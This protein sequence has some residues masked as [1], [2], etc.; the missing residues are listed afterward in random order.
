VRE[1]LEEMVG[2][3][4][5]G[6][7]RPQ[8]L[9]ELE[10]AIQEEMK[11]WD[12]TLTI[13]V[14]SPD[15]AKVFELG[16]SLSVD[17]GVLT[18]A[19]RKGNGMQ[20]A[21][22]LALTQAWAGALRKVREADAESKSRTG[23]NT[24]I[25]AIEEPELYLHPHAERRHY[26]NLLDLA[27]AEEHQVFLSSHS[28]HFVDL[29][30]PKSICIL[31]KPDVETGTVARQCKIELFAGDDA[32]DRKKR[33][34]AARWVNPVRGEMLF[35]RRVAFVEG[36]TEAALFPFLADKLGCFDPEVSVIECA[37]K[38]N[39]LLYVEIAKVF[40]LDFIVVHDE[41]PVAENLEGDK[42]KTARKTYAYNEQ[43]ARL[44]ADNKRVEMC[45]PDLEGMAGILGGKK[46]G[47]PLTAIEHFGEDGVEI[48][49]RLE[50]V[51]RAVY[52]EE[53]GV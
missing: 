19:D 33:F 37:S 32:A 3:L 2:H 4:N 44:V 42:L 34:R 46:L 15:I 10:S 21:L 18:A 48:P 30:R 26:R 23:S 28:T 22:M 13:N 47:K 38:F 1:K 6:D 8:Q 41:D 43:I 7:E 36:E 16:T 53:A 45:K 14:E 39:L 9:A 50:E 52:A 51:V 11:G 35:A 17:D 12:A 49:E 40:E 31:H 24:V 27:G 29:E 5:E 20:R 25:L